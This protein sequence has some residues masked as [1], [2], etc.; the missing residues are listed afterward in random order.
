M[1]HIR[2]IARLMVPWWLFVDDGRKVIE[3]LGLLVDLF[4]QKLRDGLDAR[5]PSRAGASA[6]KLIGAYRLIPRGRDE[7]TAHY[8]ERLIAWRYPRGHR[9]RGGAFGLL[10]QVYHYWGGAPCWTHDTNQNLRALDVD[11]TPSYSYG[12]AWDWDGGSSANWG[13]QWVVVDLSATAYALTAYEPDGTLGI[14]GTTPGDWAA[15]RRLVDPLD[16]HQWMAAGTQPEWMIVSLD[17]ADPTPD[18]TWERW[19][20]MSGTDLVP[21]RSSS[22]RYVALRA[23]LKE[24]A[25][26]PTLWANSSIAGLGTIT[27]DATSFPLTITTPAG[28][29]AGDSASFP[30]TITLP[31]DGDSVE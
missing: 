8:A 14:G 22:C 17:G 11:E 23:E 12:E 28:A 9:V 7:T 2:H 16:P 5:F 15:M 25:G 21:A 10:T 30:A 6:I 26:D 18:A 29:Y 4:R 13:R 31:D 20:V 27:G 24:Y 3:G 1:A 19:G